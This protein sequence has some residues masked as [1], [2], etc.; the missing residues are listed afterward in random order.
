VPL[1]DRSA[2]ERTAAQARG[3]QLRAETE[4][5]RRTLR[6]Q[7]AAWRAAVV[8]R[9]AIADRYRELVTATA[10][11]IERIAQVSYDAGERSILELLDAFRTSASARVRQSTLDAAVRT[12]EIEL[13]F[14]SGWEIP[15]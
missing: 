8:E 2:P 13:E 6:S 10:G 15:E 4:A 12:A 11:E 9:R 7:I 1:F 3:G 14:L 5:F